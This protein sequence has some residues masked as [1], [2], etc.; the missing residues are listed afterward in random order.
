MEATV[1][2]QDLEEYDPEAKLQKDA[3]QGINIETMSLSGSDIDENEENSPGV[4]QYIPQ[5]NPEKN[6]EDEEET[7]A[8]SKNPEKKT[9]KEDILNLGADDTLIAE[10]LG[11]DVKQGVSSNEYSSDSDDDE[12]DY[13]ESLKKIDEDIFK[14]TLFAYHPETRQINYKELL[15]LSNV[16]RNKRGQ[17]IDPLHKTIP[18]LTCYEKARILGMRAKQINNGGQPFIDVPRNIIDGHTIALM[19]LNKQKI[20]FIIRRPIPNGG[21]E[22]WK[23]S[24]LKILE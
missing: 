1:V 19:E 8:E 4:D 16:V 18:F 10:N 11:I 12:V 6:I 24:D 5:Q 21:S 14:D 15:T 3:Q 20:P 23:V 2:S 7:S 13:N 22:Y 17:I 9:I